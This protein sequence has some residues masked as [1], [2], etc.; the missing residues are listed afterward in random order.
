MKKVFISLKLHSHEISNDES[1]IDT[2]PWMAVGALGAP[3]VTAV[4]PAA[5]E[6]RSDQDSA[7]IQDQSTEG[8]VARGRERSSGY[9]I[10]SHVLMNTSDNMLEKL[11][12]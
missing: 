11:H 4:D 10:R 12:F 3:G 1:K 7:T 2:T 6:P 8:R 5:L 9:A